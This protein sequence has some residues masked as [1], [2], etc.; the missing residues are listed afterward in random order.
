MEILLID[1]GSTDSTPIIAKALACTNATVKYTFQKNSG[2]SSARNLGLD[3]ASGD[4]I[5][6]VD[7]D[8]VLSPDAVDHL[9]DPISRGTAQV[10]HMHYS[11]IGD[12]LEIRESP[13]LSV[14]PRLY[15]GKNDMNHL[16]IT[17]LGGDE[18]CYLSLF[19]FPVS[20]ARRARF[21][22]NRGWMEDTV[23]LAKILPAVESI[24]VTDFRGYF[25]FH[26]RDG[27]TWNSQF[28]RRNVL[29]QPSVALEISHTLSDCNVSSG[30]RRKVSAARL[31]AL[32]RYLI[33]SFANK[34]LDMHD[35]VSF[36]KEM[37]HDTALRQ[38]Y[39]ISRGPRRIYFKPMFFAIRHNCHALL[40]FSIYPLMAGYILKR[41]MRT[42]TCHFK[43]PLSRAF[44]K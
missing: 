11:V 42:R 38:I 33:S 23:Y 19:L 31:D 5:L 20:L 41:F 35:L 25:Y 27:A 16:I 7:A 8:D 12:Y 13:P 26:N 18:P 3:L 24:Y 36:T 1:D 43:M 40:Y 28:V 10:S 30:V 21:N 44:P 4:Y 15:V 22:E 32:G 17:F 37:A 2:V 14:V 9:A 34:V 6:F 29:E 39:T